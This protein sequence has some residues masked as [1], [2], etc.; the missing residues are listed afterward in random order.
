M[1]EIRKREEGVRKISLRRHSIVWR[2]WERRKRHI[3][4]VK[5]ISITWSD[6]RKNRWRDRSYPL[7]KGNG[8]KIGQVV[9]RWSHKVVP[10]DQKSSWKASPPGWEEEQRQAWASSCLVLANMSKYCAGSLF[11][12]LLPWSKCWIRMFI[13]TH[14]NSSLYLWAKKAQNM[15][16]W[17]TSAQL[18]IS[19]GFK[20]IMD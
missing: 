15:S 11:Y 9:I 18:L 19:G 10:W 13:W 17:R 20:S 6:S 12:T 1:G 7:V 8:D 16:I 14:L 4:V 5:W 3:Y 2:N